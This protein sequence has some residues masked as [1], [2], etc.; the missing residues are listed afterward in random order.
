MKRILID[1]TPISC[2]IDGLTQY[3]LNVVLRLDYSAYQY[4]LLLRPN[5]CPEHYLDRLRETNIQIE[6]VD[7]SPIGPLRDIQ[8]ARYLRKCCHFD[9]VF[10]PSNQFPLALRLP[11]I[12]VVHD[13]IYEQFPEQLGKLCRLKRCYLRHV[14]KKG[15]MRA[16]YVIAVSNYTKNEII[17][18]YGA[19]YQDKIQVVY[20][21]W[22]HLL[23]YQ[24]EP[25]QNI[26]IH[27]QKYM[28]YVGSSRGHKNLSR[29]IAAIQQCAANLP[30]TFGLV[31]VGNQQMFT[32]QQL[33]VIREI[34]SQREIIQL[35]GWLSNSDLAYCF[36]HANAFIFPSL[37]EGFGI[38]VLEAYFHKV[39]LLLSNQSS[40]P[41]V[42]GEAAIYFNPT[43]I[44]DIANT[45]IRFVQEKNHDDLIQKQTCRMKLYSWKKAAITIS[46]IITSIWDTK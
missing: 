22:E 37:C 26:N 10:I 28:L 27:F 11:T 19:Q 15:L 40:L 18:C 45:I 38:P 33:Q 2:Q 31:I 3:I 7:I 13:L 8:F 5:Q 43:D 35:T 30:E 46:N 25:P 12:Y 4:T 6:E 17:R 42:A 23:D 41:E 16:K 24:I 1:G 14:L 20:E 44:N 34:N 9:A 21:G 32:A 36:Q 39:P 29:L